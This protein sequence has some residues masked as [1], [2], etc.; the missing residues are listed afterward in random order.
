MVSKSA[1]H[2]EIGLPRVKSGVPPSQ[3]H[4]RPGPP[5]KKD[6]RH[7]ASSRRD[8]EEAHAA[9]SLTR[10]RPIAVERGS[11]SVSV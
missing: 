8:V 5:I 4:H 6:R 9:A 11:R 2:L 3:V 10:T 7:V 1:A